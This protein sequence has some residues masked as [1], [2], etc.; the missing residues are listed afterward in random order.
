MRLRSILLVVAI[1]VVAAVCVRL[2]F[3]QLSRLHQKRVINDAL[4]A[5]L[6]APPVRMAD[7]ALPLE[8]VR[9]RRVVVEGRYDETRQVLLGGRSHAGSPGVEVVTP[10]RVSDSL[11]VLVDRGWLYAPDAATARPDRYPEPG[12]VSVLGVADSLRH[13]AGGPPLRRLAPDSTVLLSARWL[14]QDSLAARFP[15]AL[16]PYVLRQ[17]PG[18]GV[19]ANPVRRPPAPVD[20][21]MHISYAVQWFLFAAIL[22]GGSAAVAW[23]RRRRG[24]SV[25]LVPRRP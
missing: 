21:M 13:G 5:A 4:V 3:W 12:A 10:L 14:D 15:Y 18:P 2:G 6:T 22:V 17:L 8:A 20:E 9:G 16:A 19:P 25:E 23:S 7:R 24:R 11:A 1:A